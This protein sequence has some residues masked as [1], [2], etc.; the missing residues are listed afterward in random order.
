MKKEQTGIIY[1]VTNRV[2]GK[3]Y[4]GQTTQTLTKRKRQHLRAAFSLRHPNNKFYNAIRKYGEELFVWEI[5][6]DDISIDIL[7]ELEMYYINQYDSLK[8]GYNSTEGGKSVR[9][10]VH[11]EETRRKIG[12]AQKTLQK[13]SLNS[14]FDST[15]YLF[16]HKSGF[17]E[18]CT[19]NELYTKYSLNRSSVS[20]L[21]GG[22]CKSVKGW[23]LKQ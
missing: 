15:E 11:S 5:I 8:S 7:D 13:G 21:T 19:K 6:K 4:I 1:R 22:K 9:G 20:K 23:R 16:I 10:M 12:N 2:N 18:R 14:N 3:V 17:I